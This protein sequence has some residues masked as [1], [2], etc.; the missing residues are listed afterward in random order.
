MHS[1][2]TEFISEQSSMSDDSSISEVEGD[3][4]HNNYSINKKFEEH[5]VPTDWKKFGLV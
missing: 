3:I 4:L 2:E 5:K 1:Q